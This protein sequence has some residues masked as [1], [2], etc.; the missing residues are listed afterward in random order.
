[1]GSREAHLAQA[2]KLSARAEECRRLA[3]TAQDWPT[4]WSYLELARKYKVLATD[5]EAL[6]AKYS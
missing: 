4:A 1:M 6:A 5:E 3:K 2:Q